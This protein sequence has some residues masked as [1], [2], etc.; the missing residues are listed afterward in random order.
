MKKWTRLFTVLLAAAAVLMTASSVFASTVTTNLKDYLEPYYTNRASFSDVNMGGN[1]Y[2]GALCFDTFNGVAGEADFNLEKHF[3]NMTFYVGHQDSTKSLSTRTVKIFADEKLIYEREIHN[4]DLPAK[5]SIS[6]TGVKQLRIWVSGSSGSFKTGLGGIQVVSDGFTREQKLD[7]VK[8]NLLANVK[9]Y[10]S[11]RYS[12]AEEA[13]MGDK[14]W[15]NPLRFDSFNNVTARAYFNLEGNYKS[16]SFYAGHR[17]GGGTN[18]RALTI[19]G[20]NEKVLYKTTI[21]YNQ[22]PELIKV[23][24]TGVHQLLIQVGG[25]GGSFNTVIG[26]ANLVSNG[27]VRSVSLDQTALSFNDNNKSAFLKATIVPEDASNKSLKWTSSDSSVAVVS[28]DGLVTAVGPGECTITVTTVSGGYTASC[29]V[30]SSVT[31]VEKIANKITASGLT[32]TAK[33]KAQSGSLKASAEGGAKLTFTSSSSA[34]K[35]SSSGKVTVRKNYAGIASIT[36]KSAPTERYNA[37]KKVVKVTVKPAR[38]V[39]TLKS[40]AKKQLTVKWT[41]LT[42]VTGYQIQYSRSSGFSSKVTKKVTKPSTASMTLKNLQAGK[43]YYVRVRAYVKSGSSMVYSVWS[44][45]KSVTVR[46]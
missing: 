43:K 30:T 8:S 23:D 21:A 22:L 46:K 35:V 14:I 44:A 34:V 19:F 36:I 27:I 39:V 3:K 41:K 20:D 15:A 31:K 25:S 6:L 24:V 10:Q 17:Q 18:N 16:F 40:S 28:S 5:G 7:P 29:K 37:A 33:N 11:N 4:G 9:P 38:P 12:T 45:K 13:V 26:G 42:Y 2:E 32:F 1:T